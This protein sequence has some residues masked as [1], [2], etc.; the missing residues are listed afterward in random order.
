MIRLDSV[1]KIYPGAERPAVEQLSFDCEA[2]TLTALVGES[3]CGKTTT[4]KMIN[5]LIEPTSGTISIDGNDVLDVDP[6][7]LRRRIGY[8]LQEIGLFPHYSI[9]ENVAIVPS[10]LGQGQA[11]IDARVDELLELVGLPPAQFRSRYPHELS[12]GQQQRVGVARALAGRP[13]VV[14]M[15]EPFGAIDPLIRS[16]LRAE[17]T[18]IRQRLSLT[19]VMVTHDMAEALLL[20]DR[21]VVMRDG[22][23][24]A[25]DTPANLLN[26]PDDAYV[27]GLLAKPI[28]QVRQLAALGRSP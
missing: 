6:I 16:E 24:A 13:D 17:L 12:G 8:V 3:G 19:I 20:A 23:L 15:D 21:I 7:A 1:T 22:A 10:L 5:R 4:L 27:T 11:A 14:L 26:R 25:W 2:G 18:A 9:A 28:E